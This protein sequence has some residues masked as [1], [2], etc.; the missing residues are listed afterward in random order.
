[1]LPLAASPNPGGLKMKNLKPQ[2][3]LFFC[4][5]QSIQAE[6]DCLSETKKVKATALTFSFIRTRDGT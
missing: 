1:L 5:L 3:V 2:K 4:F 6:L